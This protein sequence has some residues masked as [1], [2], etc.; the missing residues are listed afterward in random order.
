[1]VLHCSLLG[2]MAKTVFENSK[3]NVTQL[4]YPFHFTGEV[5]AE[6]LLLATTAVKPSLNNWAGGSF[7]H[8]V[9]KADTYKSML[10]TILDTHISHFSR[11]I[12]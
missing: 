5:T 6:C 10:N 3:C 2:V 7:L 1:M 12:Y 9:F 4:P 11:Y 8:V